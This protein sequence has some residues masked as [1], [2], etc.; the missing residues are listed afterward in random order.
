MKNMPP[1]RQQFVA[2]DEDLE[3]Q[4]DPTSGRQEKRINIRGKDREVTIQM[5]PKGEVPKTDTVV[6]A[7]NKLVEFFPFK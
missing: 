6:E 7:W 5:Y 3:M 2:F 4:K 1:G